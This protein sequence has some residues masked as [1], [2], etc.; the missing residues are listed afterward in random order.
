VSEAYEIEL[1]EVRVAE[2]MATLEKLYAYAKERGDAMAQMRISE[3]HDALKWY[4]DSNAK[5]E[6]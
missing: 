3:L 1:A 2:L 5:G 6:E 4:K